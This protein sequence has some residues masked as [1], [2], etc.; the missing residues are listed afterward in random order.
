MRR[1]LK[2]KAKPGALVADHRT[3]ARRFLGVVWVDA[4]D[5]A[6]LADHYAPA[7]QVL[8]D[9]PHVRD[10]IAQGALEL[11]DVLVARALPSPSDFKPAA[12]APSAKPTTS[13]ARNAKE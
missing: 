1:Y 4:T 12:A 5:T 8:E 2:I 7:E 9:H 6:S 10:A 3:D 13:A 11:L